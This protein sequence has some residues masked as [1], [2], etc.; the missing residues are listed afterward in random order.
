L[1]SRYKET[2]ESGRSL[3]DSKTDGLVYAISRMP[4]TYSVVYTLLNNLIEQGIIDGIES[5]FD[6][7]SGTGAGY[8]ATKEIFPD[9]EISLFE[10]DSNMIQT[11]KKLDEDKDV[12][13]F[14][15]IK[16]E[17]EEK[18]DLVMTSY[19]LSEMNEE[20]RMSSVKK[21]INAS[22]R[23][24]LLIDTGTPRTHENF[25]KIKRMVPECGRNV[26]APCM[27]EKCG[28][29]NDYCQF[30]ARVERSSLQKMAKEASLSYEDE[31]YF[32][33]L[34]AKDDVKI[35]QSRVIRRPIIKTNVTELKVCDSSGVREVLVTKK[36]KEIYKKSK[37]TKINELTDLT[38]L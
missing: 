5:V 29:K 17:F 24:V 30:Y 15:F 11:F 35:K 1:T 25:M 32:Y 4:A 9:A 14:D 28:L 8:F 21:M 7:G 36:N 19:V 3:I 16:D 34:L 27:T 6:V 2:R 10:R 13:R 20:G 26:I 37:K 31:K 23:Y 38:E 22:N 12:V 18:A 33:L